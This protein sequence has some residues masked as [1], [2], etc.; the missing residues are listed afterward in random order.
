MKY[1]SFYKQGISLISM[2]KRGEAV[3][4]EKRQLAFLLGKLSPQVPN[5]DDYGTVIGY[6]VFGALSLFSHNT[7][8]EEERR[9]EEVK[10]VYSRIEQFLSDCSSSQNYLSAICNL[11]GETERRVDD[12]GRLLLDQNSSRLFLELVDTFRNRVGNP[13][14]R[15]RRYGLELDRAVEQRGVISGNRN[16]MIA[17]YNDIQRCFIRAKGDRRD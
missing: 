4:A 3:S 13:L 2:T 8:S 16:S 1:Y 7:S 9:F 14:D 11:Q 5:M 12:L 17:D 6:C 10:S 15:L